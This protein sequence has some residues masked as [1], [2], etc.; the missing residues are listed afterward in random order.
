MERLHHIL[1]WIGKIHG[2]SSEGWKETNSTVSPPLRAFVPLRGTYSTATYS[3]ESPTIQ[4]YS[5]PNL[6]KRNLNK[7]TDTSTNTLHIHNNNTRASK[8]C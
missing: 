5:I 2:F 1:P 4:Y 6:R 3:E 7:R 8:I